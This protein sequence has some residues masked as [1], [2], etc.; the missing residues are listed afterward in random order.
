[1]F[2]KFGHNVDQSLVEAVKK[3]MK[4]KSFAEDDVKETGLH[5]AAHA[6]AKDG[7]KTF[8]LGGKTM[9]VTVKKEEA[10]ELDELSKKT[11]G[12]YIKKAH[13]AGGMADFKHGMKYDKRGDSKD[14][15]ALAKTSA[16][17]EKGI[18][19]AVD[20]LSKEDVEQIDEIS[21][22]LAGKYLTAPHG[23]GANKYKTG[24]G[25]S[26]YPDIETMGKHATSVHRALARSKSSSLYKKPDY[27]KE[28]IEDVE[29]DEA[30]SRKHFQQVADIIKA[31]PDAK[32]RHELALHHAGIFKQQN[33]R[34]DHMK[35][36][37]AAG[38][39]MKEE[40][41]QEQ[42]TLVELST[43]ALSSYVKKAGHQNF[44]GK[45]GKSRIPGVNSA[46]RKVKQNAMMK[47]EEFELD[48][49][50]ITHAAHF[51]DP[52]TNKWASMALLTAKNDEDAVSQAHD[53]LRTDAYKNYKLSAVEKHEPVK[54]I[55]MKEEVE[56]DETTGVT[57]YNPKNQGGTR[58]EL[59]AKYA[60][61]GDPKHAEAA[62]KAG[63]TQ[64][65]LKAARAVD[66]MFGHR[67]GVDKLGI[68]KEEI[69]EL[70]ER[71]LSSAETKKKEHNVMAMKPKLKD[72]KKRYGE[73][74]GKSVMYAVATKQAKG[75]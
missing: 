60:K 68:R 72:F 49:A 2:S 43:K 75:E 39:D 56:L 37:K 74:K 62:R 13:Y 14:K 71:S 11:L 63:A 6:A 21:K 32:K 26:K 17:R 57:D 35:F 33:P 31:H 29:L 25:K 4:E 12:N 27:Y 65:E 8:K 46:L 42:N 9:P 54:N 7:K 16:K 38:V 70:D 58:K 47:K 23:K 69:E 61:S 66:S 51:D 41:E 15:M 67:G 64:S 40:V 59:L 48:E 44:Q 3:V 73:K 1:M 52:T 55:K 5:A 20:K 45:D 19:K 24:E 28:D 50:N 36:M 18:N 53:L 22:E 10:E 34:F 30:V